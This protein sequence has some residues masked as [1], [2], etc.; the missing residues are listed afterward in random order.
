MSSFHGSA[1][2]ALTAIAVMV[3]I[4]GCGACS[5]AG[6]PED[7]SASE[8]R[9]TSAAATN[10]A[11]ST[12]THTSSRHIE[13]RLDGEHCRYSG[14]DVASG[15]TE[16]TFENQTE[17]AAGLAFLAL[18]DATAGREEIDLVGTRFSVGGAPPPK[19]VRLVGVLQADPGDSATQIAPLTPGTYLIDCVTFTNAEPDEV[20]RVAVL[21]VE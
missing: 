1:R 18:V 4:V 5:D 2:R 14:P 19:Q 16:V 21:E 6:T 17:R 10:K 8:G 3:A 7:I 9:P 15:D 12:T 13:A 20:W 11:N